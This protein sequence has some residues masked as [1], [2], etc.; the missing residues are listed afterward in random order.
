MPNQVQGGFYQDD[1]SLRAVL[2]QLGHNINEIQQEIAEIKGNPE[3][4]TFGGQGQMGLFGDR[5]A[6]PR[7]NDRLQFLELLLLK[8]L[9]EYSKANTSEVTRRINSQ[10]YIEVTLLQD[11]YESLRSEVLTLANN[12]GGEEKEALMQRIDER[13]RAM[14]WIRS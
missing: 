6:V 4:P 7:N 14:E 13:F 10:K 3:P 12:L 11:E 1:L 9:T 8:Y 2:I 5:P